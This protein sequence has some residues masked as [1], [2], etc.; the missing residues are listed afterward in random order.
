MIVTDGIVAYWQLHNNG[1]TTILFLIP[2]FSKAVA[3]SWLRKY[4]C[5]YHRVDGIMLKV[6]KVNW[7]VQSFQFWSNRRSMFDCTLLFR[8]VGAG[9]KLK[10]MY[11]KREIVTFETK[12]NLFHSNVRYRQNFCSYLNNHVYKKQIL[13]ELQRILTSPMLLIFW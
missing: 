8:L 12:K 2:C 1:D 10:P 13:L 9:N 5:K 3:H 11:N 4:L 7:H 6:A